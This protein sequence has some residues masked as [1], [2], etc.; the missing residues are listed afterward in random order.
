MRILILTV[1]V[2]IAVAAL[3]V[4]R[5]EAEKNVRTAAASTQN[6]PN[7]KITL[8]APRT[9]LGKKDNVNLYVMIMNDDAI[10]DVYIYSELGF[11]ARAELYLM[12]RD[13]RGREVPTRFIHDDR[14]DT[15]DLNDPSTFVKL[16]P[17]NFFGVGYENSIYNLNLEQP[18]TY[19]LSVEYT[20]PI[21]SSEVKVKPFWGSESGSIVSN[22]VAITVRP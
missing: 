4:N 21:S 7:L 19:N 8:L 3:Q 12:R 20:C 2:L 6:K 13:A 5:I 22:V 10:H 16:S 1:V 15:L 17:G 11:G 9:I 18:G 14:P